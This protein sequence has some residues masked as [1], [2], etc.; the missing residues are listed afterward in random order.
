M[1]SSGQ[2][3]TGGASDAKNN[4]ERVIRTSPVAGTWTIRVD[5]AN[6]P[7]GGPQGFALVA[8]GDILP[9]GT[10]TGSV[11]TYCT[12]KLNSLF[13][14]PAIHG[15]GTP[16]ASSGSGFTVSCTNVINQKPGLLLYSVTGRAASAFTGGTLCVA[17]P[18]KRTPGMNSGGSP[19]GGDDCSGVYAID[20]NAFTIGALGGTPLAALQ[21]P[22]TQVDAQFWGRDNGYSIPNNTT[23]SNGLEFTQC[24]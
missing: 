22:G 24:P 6:V 4:V 12:A 1:F 17:S 13:C 10:C 19:P 8:T 23:L 16:S 5:A 14:L 2:S 3:T 7:S 9:P 18:I 20:F 11:A 21:T 15:T